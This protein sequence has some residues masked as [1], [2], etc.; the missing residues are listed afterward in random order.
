MFS[1]ISAYV[2]RHHLALLALFFALGGTA[3]AAGNKLLP[4]NS[5]G[6]AQVV[7]GSLQKV[8]LSRKAITALKGNRGAPGARGATGAA[9]PA[10]PGGAQGAPGVSAT[11]LFAHVK[12]DGTLSPVSRGATSATRS[13]KGV[14]VV[15]FNQSVQGCVAVAQV[16]FVQGDTGSFI[17]DTFAQTVVHTSDVQV[18][19]FRADTSAIDGTFNLI[20]VC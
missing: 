19:L 8:D 18:S 2:R 10:G 16:G 1:R 13:S 20:V 14:Y 5:V 4:K 9:G 12:D 3:I 11:R 6:T 17:S 15:T 7:N